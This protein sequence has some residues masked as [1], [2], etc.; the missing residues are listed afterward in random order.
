[1]Q[2]GG[3]VGDCYFD[4]FAINHQ[5]ASCIDNELQQIKPWYAGV[6][7]RGWG[8]G[9]NTSVTCASDV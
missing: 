6:Y 8:W 1:M 7:G 9:G 2:N 5:N 4:S 3:G